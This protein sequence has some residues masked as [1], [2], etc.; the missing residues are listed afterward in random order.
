MAGFCDIPE[1]KYIWSVGGALIEYKG[2]CFWEDDIVDY[3][4][5]LFYEETGKDSYD[6][7]E[8]FCAFL[9]GFG[10]E[11]KYEMENFSYKPVEISNSVLLDLEMA[12]TSEALVGTLE[13]FKIDTIIPEGFLNECIQTIM[14]WETKVNSAAK[15]C[16]AELVKV[17]PKVNKDR[18]GDDDWII[19][20]IQDCNTFEEIQNFVNYLDED[21]WEV[22]E[23]DIIQEYL[24]DVGDF[25]DISN[26]IIKKFKDT[27][28]WFSQYC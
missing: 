16:V 19:K 8:E 22:A 15:E 28:T 3:Y 21:V 18:Y 12:D 4:G 11:I 26:Q 25:N 14:N 5:E 10:D 9:S 1:L 20:S 17:L 27:S 7:E 23:Y 24:Y 2:L 13:D 6:N